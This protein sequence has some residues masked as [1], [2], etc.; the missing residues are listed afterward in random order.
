MG[1]PLAIEMAAVRVA[2]LPVQDIAARLD[3]RF[4]L[5][6][7]GDRV[8]LPRHQTLRAM[9]DGSYNLLSPAEQRLLCRLSV[10]AGGFTLEAAESVCAGEGGPGTSGC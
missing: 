2:S 10:F 3:E 4:N 1:I 5:L 6:T 7:T 9:I 8:A